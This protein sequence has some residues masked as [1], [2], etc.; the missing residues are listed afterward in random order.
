V[1]VLVPKPG[2][3]PCE[4]PSKAPDDSTTLVLTCKDY[5]QFYNMIE[6]LELHQDKLPLTSRSIAYGSNLGDDR[7]IALIEWFASTV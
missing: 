5:A 4:V 6:L 1:P 7:S 2:T 3:T